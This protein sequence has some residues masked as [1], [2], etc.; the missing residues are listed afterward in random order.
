MTDPTRP[1]PRALRALPAALAALAALALTAAPAAPAR[2]QEA[3]VRGTWTLNRAASDDLNAA[4]QTAVARLGAVLRPTV[5]AE[6]R[7]ELAP[8]GRLAI[9]STPDRV[10][11]QP[12]ARR[13]RVLALER[14]TAVTIES[15]RVEQVR[16]QWQGGRLVVTTMYGRVVETDTYAA[17]AD[18]RTLT[19]STIYRSPRLP[20]PF[21]ARAVYD[22][23]S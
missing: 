12:D 9:D 2:A 14:V 18:G 20:Q 23:A 4:I 7:R 17:S 3:S 22:R 15:G 6:L 10:S 19:V 1:F 11:L 21:A 5:G 8:P 13:A 16:A